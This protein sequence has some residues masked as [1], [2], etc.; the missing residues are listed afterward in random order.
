MNNPKDELRQI[1]LR[2]SDNLTMVDSKLDA[3]RSWILRQLPEQRDVVQSYHNESIGFNECL[4]QVK[5]NLL[6]EKI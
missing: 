6:G 3:I 5:S 2:G 4:K 1:L